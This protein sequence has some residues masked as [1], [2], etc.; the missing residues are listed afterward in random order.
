MNASV[1]DVPEFK[2]VICGDFGVGKK[3]IFE[4]HSAA[5]VPGGRRRDASL[6]V[7]IIP[8]H[9]FTTR[10]PIRFNVWVPLGQ[11]RFG[12]FRDHFYE[13]AS[14]AIVVYNVASLITYKNAPEWHRHVTRV[15]GGD[16]PVVICANK[17]NPTDQTLVNARYPTNYCSNRENRKFVDISE[18]ENYDCGE[19]VLFQWI[20]S[21]LLGDDE[22]TILSDHRLE[23]ISSTFF[24]NY[25]R[26]A[27][28]Q[29]ASSPGRSGP[30]E[31]QATA[32]EILANPDHSLYRAACCFIHGKADESSPLDTL[33]ELVEF[34]SRP[35]PA[36]PLPPPVFASSF[37]FHRPDGLFRPDYLPA[38]C[39]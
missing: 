31:A 7:D 19:A 21:K 18:R 3:D 35:P 20:A 38:K 30:T 33:G 8:L 24:F 28:L 25:S 11:E 27:N 10:G 13:N 15:C 22:L 5:E 16:T 4:L 26:E 17:V 12:G 29:T 36:K 9:F 23:S 34:L 2:L 1:H 14:C 6:S 32:M 37:D 39:D